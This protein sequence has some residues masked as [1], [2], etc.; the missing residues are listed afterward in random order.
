VRIPF[1]RGVVTASACALMLA[2][3]AE[4]EGGQVKKPAPPPKPPAAKPQGGNKA[5]GNKAGGGKQVPAQELRRLLDM[6]P[7]QRGK[8][9]A[10][11]NLTPQQRQQVQNQL[12]NLDR[13]APAQREQ[14]LNQISQLEKL[15]P[16]RQQ[17]VKGQ[18]QS[19]NGLSIADQRQFLHSPEFS[20][21]YSPEEQQIIRDRFPPANSE[22]VRPTDKLVPARRQAVQQEV[23]RIRALPAGPERREALHNP[24]F[25]QNF[26]PDEQQI[27]RDNFPNA[28]K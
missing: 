24:E 23:Q 3:T 17:A 26:S 28:A 6:P 22:V 4:L 12:D 10:N 21:K 14:R 27:I 2:W 8:A 1:I 25:N 19:M 11:S 13:M 9:L 18:I 7:E 16:A 5:G 15:P 20:Q